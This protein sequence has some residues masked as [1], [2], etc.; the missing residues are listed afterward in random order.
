MPTWCP[1]NHVFVRAVTVEVKRK[2]ERLPQSNPGLVQNQNQDRLRSANA[3]LDIYQLTPV[4]MPSW[5]GQSTCSNIDVVGAAIAIDIW[6][7]RRGQI[8]VRRPRGYSPPS[9][10]FQSIG[11]VIIRAVFYQI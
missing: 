3:S 11:P 5:A 2:T 9:G 10:K 7:P 4:G 1:P 6:E 8:S